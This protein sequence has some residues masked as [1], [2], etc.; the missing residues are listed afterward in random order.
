MLANRQFLK[1]L[2]QICSINARTI[3]P[4]RVQSHDCVDWRSVRDVP[5]AKKNR[6]HI[7][8]TY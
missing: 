3:F 2:W 5:G 1:V 8:H 7:L 4:F 6:K